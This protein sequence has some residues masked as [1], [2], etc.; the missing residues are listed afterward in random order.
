AIKITKHP[1]PVNEINTNKVIDISVHATGDECC[2]ITYSWFLNGVM[3][4]DELEKPPYKR[5]PGGSLLFDPRNV[6]DDVLS[7]RT[8]GYQCNISNNYDTAMYEFTVVVK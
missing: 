1:D 2:P 5:G 4:H 3:I 8:G 6:S 7:S